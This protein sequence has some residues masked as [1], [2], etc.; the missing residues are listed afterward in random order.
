MQRKLYSGMLLVS[1]LAVFLV[2]P[3]VL[4][5]ADQ[6]PSDKG[7]TTIFDGK[8][9]DGWHVDVPA[10]DEDPDISP[11]FVVRACTPSS[12]STTRLV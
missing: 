1:L 12:T 2:A 10:A 3:A 6:K 11:T 5:A 9:L 8:T 7:F 4:F